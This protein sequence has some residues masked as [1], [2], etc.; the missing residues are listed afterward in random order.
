[1]LLSSYM[2]QAPV[3]ALETQQMRQKGELSPL[4][5][6][7]QVVSKSQNNRTHIGVLITQW[8]HWHVGGGREAVDGMEWHVS[9]RRCH[10]TCNLNDKEASALGPAGRTFWVGGK[11]VQMPR[12]WSDTFSCLLSFY[13]RLS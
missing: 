9:L 7:G 12:G 10:L 4:Q 8:G 5:R 11:A 6:G 13:S 1:M 2:S 3:R